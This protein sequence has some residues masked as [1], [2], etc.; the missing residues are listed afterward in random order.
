M[1]YRTSSLP[2]HLINNTNCSQDSHDVSSYP[3]LDSM[4]FNVIQTSVI[5]VTYS[6]LYF[7]MFKFT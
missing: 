7:I 4:L 1:P 3:A 5:S 2:T 6:I